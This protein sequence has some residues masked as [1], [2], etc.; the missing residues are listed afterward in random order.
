MY[1]KCH[2]SLGD[3]EQ[4]FLQGNMEGWVHSH[5]IALFKP[6]LYWIDLFDHFE[7]S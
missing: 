5:V 7:G 2:A 3:L 6:V 1:R 4:A